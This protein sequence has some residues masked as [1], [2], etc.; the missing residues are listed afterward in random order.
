M[1]D[2]ACDLVAELLAGNNGS[3][4]AHALGG[5]EVVAQARGVLLNDDPG[6]LLHDLVQTWQVLGKRGK[7]HFQGID[8]LNLYQPYEEGNTISPI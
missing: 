3:L 4:L 6:H 7:K 2:R 5:V 8:L 1:C